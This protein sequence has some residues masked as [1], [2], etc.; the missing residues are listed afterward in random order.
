MTLPAFLIPLLLHTFL[1]T[2]PLRDVTVCFVRG[3]N[4]V[5]I[6]TH[7]PLAGRDSGAEIPY[8]AFVISTHTPLAGRD[9]YHQTRRLRNLL[10]LLTRPLR[11]VTRT[12][13]KPWRSRKISTHTPLAGRDPRRDRI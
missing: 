6:S 9:Q 3:R 5:K 1:L 4:K 7:T 12:L 13:W 8:T 11:D 2:R 10:F